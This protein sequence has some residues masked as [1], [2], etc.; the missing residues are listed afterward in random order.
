MRELNSR[1]NNQD[2]QIET[3]TTQLAIKPKEIITTVQDV[4][5]LDF[6]AF[7]YHFLTFI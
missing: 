1:F 5:I 6:F 4:K 2:R 7:I 3:L